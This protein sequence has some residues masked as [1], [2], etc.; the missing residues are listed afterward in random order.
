MLGKRLMRH[1]RQL[2]QAKKAFPNVYLLV[3]IPNDEIT[4]QEKGATVMSARERVE[5]V[6]HCKWVDEV[7]PPLAPLTQVIENAPW[8]VTPEFLDLHRIDYVAH[9]DLPYPGPGVS[10]TYATVKKLGKFLPTKRTGGVSSSDIIARCYGFCLQLLSRKED[11]KTGPENA[12][13]RELR[14]MEMKV[15]GHHVVEENGNGDIR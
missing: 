9:D 11:G 14:R 15:L 5:T 10:D 2:E 12:R 8:V 3:G 6:K 1:M 7:S 13:S 4:R